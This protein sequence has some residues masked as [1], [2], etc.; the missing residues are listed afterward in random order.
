MN[1]TG[2]S[3]Q[4]EDLAVKLDCPVYDEGSDALIDSCN[5]WVEGVTQTSVA[6]PG[7]IGKSR[8]RSRFSDSFVS[9]LM[10]TFRTKQIKLYLGIGLHNFFSSGSAFF[11]I[12]AELLRKVSFSLEKGSVVDNKDQPAKEFR[13]L[14][15]S[16]LS[17]LSDRKN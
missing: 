16:Y 7:L 17:C 6:I 2:S 12:L 14:Q 8:S 11:F 5:F 4:V 13:T 10:T 1:S 9:T 15:Q 3:N